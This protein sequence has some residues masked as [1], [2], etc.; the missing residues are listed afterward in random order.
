MSFLAEYIKF[1]LMDHEIKVLFSLVCRYP[2][3]VNKLGKES[4]VARSMVYETFTVNLKSF[5]EE[6]NGTTTI[7]HN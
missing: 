4:N 5:C 2:K 1:G 6:K 7:H 3:A